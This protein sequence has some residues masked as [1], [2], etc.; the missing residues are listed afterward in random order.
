MAVIAVGSDFLDWTVYRFLPQA[1]WFRRG[2]LLLFVS[3]LAAVYL[4]YTVV[5]DLRK[6]NVWISISTRNAQIPAIVQLQLHLFAP[7]LG[8]LYKAGFEVCV[9]L[10]EAAKNIG[11][12]FE[13]HKWKLKLVFI[14]NLHPFYG[15][16]ILNLAWSPVLKIVLLSCDQKTLPVLLFKIF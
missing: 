12:S 1:V 10:V 6:Q 15:I 5:L 8:F 3:G 14:N 11:D 9:S 4:Y 16:T 2:W 7:L 13:V